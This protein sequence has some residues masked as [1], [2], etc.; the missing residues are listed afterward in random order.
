MMRNREQG[1]A[2]HLAGR[3]GQVKPRPEMKADIPTCSPTLAIGMWRMLNRSRFRLQMIEGQ[4]ATFS[5]AVETPEEAVNRDLIREELRRLELDER[6][7][8]KQITHLY[9]KLLLHEKPK[10]QSIDGSMNLSCQT[11]AT[12]AAERLHGSGGPKRRWS[13]FRQ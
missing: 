6:Y 4:L 5:Q 11:A 1:L 13:L 2:F 12:G 7:Y 8:S 9:G 10:L 3:R